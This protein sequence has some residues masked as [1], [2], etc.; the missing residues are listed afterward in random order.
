MMGSF[1]QTSFWMSFS[2]SLPHIS[3][4]FVSLYAFLYFIHKISST[5]NKKITKSFSDREVLIKVADFEFG[6]FDLEIFEFVLE[7]TLKTPWIFNWE[8]RTHPDVADI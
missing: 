3:F 2:I 4:T 6:Y 1:I 8:N 7:N 5:P